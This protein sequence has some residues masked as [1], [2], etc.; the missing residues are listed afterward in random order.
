MTRKLISGTM[1]L[2]GWALRLFVLAILIAG[3]SACSSMAHYL[4]GQPI[5]N[6]AAGSCDPTRVPVLNVHW[7]KDS[8]GAWRVMG[9]IENKSNQVIGSL[10]TG[11][12]TRTKFDR[13]ADQGEDVTV[14]PLYL[15]P[16][17]KAPFI[18]WIDRDIPNLDHFEVEVVNCVVAEEAQRSH[19]DIS[20]DKVTVDSIGQAE[21]I[22]ELVNPGTQTVL[23]NGFMAAV[24]DSKGNMI[25]AGY[26][27]V[28]PRYLAP[29][30]SGAM[31][32]TLELPPG[33]G[34][35]I[36][37]HRFFMDVLVQAVAV[38]L[39][40][41]PARDVQ[42]LSHYTD[43]GGQFHLLG[44][45]T[46]SS[47]KPV[48]TAL[49]ASVYSADKSQLLDAG[50]YA[51]W[52]P[53]AP[54]ETLPFD[55]RDWGTLDNLP[56]GL[57]GAQANINISLRLEPFLSWNSNT[58]AVKLSLV[59]STESFE[60]ET[61]I[62]SGQVQNDSGSGITSGLVLLVVKQKSD[63]KIVAVGNVHLS[64]TDL[65]APGAV[66]DYSLKLPLPAGLDANTLNAE[67]TALGYQP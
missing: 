32:A 2:H 9:E 61:A 44:Q 31:R 53:L 52:L 18:A 35:A 8:E 40:L 36:S 34:A 42:I 23:V 24:Y 66:L 1:K 33:A 58:P 20:G 37:S 29:G 12:E 10:Q 39:P 4:W 30:E 28:T 5:N 22:G 27:Q 62:F 6:Q 49:Q 51:T 67:V 57:T 17:E 65:A 13:P 47:A 25:S 60:N 11:V 26:A 21:V 3:T 41:D 54:G 48:M 63:G 14:S 59:S 7:F 45:L 43:T 46:N 38:A 15:K 55:I 50:Q 19:V 56:K 64:I 16:G